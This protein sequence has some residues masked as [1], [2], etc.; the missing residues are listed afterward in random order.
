MNH[1]TVDDCL[2]GSDSVEEGIE[3][4]R[5]LKE[6][7]SEAEILLC[8]WNSSSPAVLEAIPAELRDSHTSLTNLQHR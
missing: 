4:H 7:F 2:A 1:F 6:L 3:I 8:K 5:Q